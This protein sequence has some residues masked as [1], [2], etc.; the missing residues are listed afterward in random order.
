MT[1][2][3]LLAVALA[4]AGLCAACQPVRIIP[5]G[6]TMARCADAADMALAQELRCQEQIAIVINQQ[7]V[8]EVRSSDLLSEML[9]FRDRE[10]RVMREPGIPDRD[11]AAYSAMYESLAVNRD[12]QIV[13]CKELY[14]TLNGSINAWAGKRDATVREWFIYSEVR[15][16]P[17]E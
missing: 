14:S 15:P 7:D 13:R 6:R 8:I 10:A 4:A 16:V 5:E 3:A 1:S 2:R 12:A 9:S 11:R 17:S